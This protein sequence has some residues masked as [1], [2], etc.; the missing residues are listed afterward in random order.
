V[1]LRVVGPDFALSFDRVRAVI[2]GWEHAGRPLL[3]AGPRLNFWRATTDND[4]GWDNAAAWRKAGLHWLQHR[5]D[6]VT[7][8]R[9]GDGVVRLTAHVRIAPPVLDLAFV[10]DYAYTL[11][12]RGD[13]VLTAHGVPQGE[14]PP[15]LPRIGLQMTLPDALDRVAW[16]GRGPGEGYRDSKQAQRFGLWTARVDD[17]YTPYIFP[18]ENGNRTDVSWVA[19]TDARGGGLM[20]IG[21]EALNFSAHRFPT[22]DLERA[23]HTVELPRRDEITVS[24]DHLHQGLGSGSCGPGPWPPHQLKPQEFRFTVRLRPC[25]RDAGS[26]A[27]QSRWASM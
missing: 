3:R 5:V 1:A 14:W 4:R 19:F 2:S 8:E 13:V 27:E 16:Y 24:L 18:Q 7:V 21:D 22:A 17:L 11:H 25:S 26:L 12:G 6:G 10:C 23:R 9:V 15:T 20:A